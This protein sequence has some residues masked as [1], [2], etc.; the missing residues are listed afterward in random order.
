MKRLFPFP[1]VPKVPAGIKGEERDF[2]N[3]LVKHVKEQLRKVHGQT[4]IHDVNR[5][6]TTLAAMS[7]ASVTWTAAIPAGAL[8]LGVTARVVTLITGATTFNIGDGTDADRWGA[9]IALAKGTVTT[10][11]NFTITSPVYYAA[12][13]NIVL[14]KNG[15]NFTAGAVKLTVYY[16]LLNAPP[17]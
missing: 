8:V 2:L 7:G 9:S 15:N 16:T 10:G 13:T 12:A 5:D 17:E 3:E 6:G 11:A 1:P 14:T 4:V